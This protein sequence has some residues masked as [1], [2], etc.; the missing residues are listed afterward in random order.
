M[1]FGQGNDLLLPDK[2]TPWCIPLPRLASWDVY[3][4]L[5]KQLLRDNLISERQI[6]SRT[7][8]VS[9]LDRTQI[10]DTDWMDLSGMTSATISVEPAGREPFML[11][12]RY[13]GRMAGRFPDYA[14]GFLYWHVPED[15]PYGAE[16]RLRCAESLEHFV[17]GHDL[18]TPSEE[19]PWSLRLRGLAQQ[20]ASPL[21]GPLLAYLK[22]AGLTDE[23][24]IDIL[25]KTTITHMRDLFLVRFHLHAV[26]VRL[27]TGS[28]SCRFVFYNMPWVGVYNGAA[29]ARL[30]V[31]D[32]TPTFILLGMR[33]VT[34]LNGS[35]TLSDGKASSGV[36]P[37]KEGQLVYRSFPQNKHGR[38]VVRSRIVQK[39]S[40][41][42]RV[43]MEIMKQSGDNVDTYREY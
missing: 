14:R 25:S 15:D 2:R 39:S 13:N 35:R 37:P 20:G 40:K 24:V 1:E 30:V 42:G 36:V 32:D 43:L 9:T 29:L 11:R 5:R 26:P 28:L 33:I 18:P 4:P 3:T 19:R 12:I 31:L 8:V 38:L 27:H 21:S 17:R 23:S 34:L 7:C 10:T 16:L 22:E 6:R 41:E